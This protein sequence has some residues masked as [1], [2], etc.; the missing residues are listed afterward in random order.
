[1]TDSIKAVTNILVKAPKSKWPLWINKNDIFTLTSG[2][3]HGYKHK[4]SITAYMRRF[5]QKPFIEVYQ[6]T[7]VEGVREQ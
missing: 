2:Y 4:W 6:S 1:M 3:C 7:D 5:S